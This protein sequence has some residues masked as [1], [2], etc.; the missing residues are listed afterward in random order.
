MHFL[1]QTFTAAAATKLCR[2]NSQ[3]VTVPLL[4]KFLCS[5]RN[6]Q[7]LILFIELS[8]WVW[9]VYRETKRR[10]EEAKQRRRKKKKKENEKK[11]K[12]KKKKEEFFRFGVATELWQAGQDKTYT[13][14]TFYFVVNHEVDCESYILLQVRTLNHPG[15][16]SD[17]SV[18]RQKQKT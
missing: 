9:V 1:V 13:M 10:K 16:D 2:C 5:K 11:K 18:K 3:I 4:I 8:Q 7:W 6:L 14:S 17:L 15:M 12:T